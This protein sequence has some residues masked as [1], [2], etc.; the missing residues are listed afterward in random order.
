SF[1]SGCCR[2]CVPDDLTAFMAYHAIVPSTTLAV[3]AMRRGV[4]TLPVSGRLYDY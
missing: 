4:P 3:L 1:Y 2:S